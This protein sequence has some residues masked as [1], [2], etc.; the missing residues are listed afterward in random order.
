M[1]RHSAKCGALVFE[2]TKVTSVE[3]EGAPTD[4]RPISV[5]WKTAQGTTGK[6]TFDY[7]IDASGRN[8]ILSTKYLNSRKFNNSLKNVA[9][10][11][12]WKNTGMYKHGTVRE[13]SP[14]FEALSGQCFDV[15]RQDLITYI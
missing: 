1:L 15:L 4:S 11:G 9:S 3:F 2:E 12:Y 13:G 5:S 8:G 14:F 10:W 7:L 6:T